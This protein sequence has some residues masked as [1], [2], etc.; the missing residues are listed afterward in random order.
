M[1]VCILC[2][3]ECVYI[4]IYMKVIVGHPSVHICVIRIDLKKMSWFGKIITN[5]L[6]I[7]HSK[8]SILTNNSY[9]CNMIT[10]E[11]YS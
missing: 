9:L 8:N 2:M 1:F 3:Y 4:C 5:Q 7:P 10:P 11:K 6:A